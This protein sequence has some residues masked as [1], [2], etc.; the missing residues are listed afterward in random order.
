MFNTSGTHI[1]V[2]GSLILLPLPLHLFNTVAI[3]WRLLMLIFIISGLTLHSWL[4][5]KTHSNEFTFN[6]LQL[7]TSLLKQI[8]S[9]QTQTFY[10][11]SIPLTNKSLFAPL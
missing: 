7:K 9:S 6:T 1:F 3:K 10:T 5:S 8:F 2:Y 4:V 11:I